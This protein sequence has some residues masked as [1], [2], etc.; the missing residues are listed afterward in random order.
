MRLRTKICITITVL[1]LGLFFAGISAVG[2][3]F[4]IGTPSQDHWILDD[5]VMGA[6]LAPFA[7]CLL[8]G[9]VFFIISGVLLLLDLRSLLKAQRVGRGLT[10]SR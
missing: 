2:Q 5:Q 3:R 8:P 4:L 10:G 1:L 6:G 7:Y 9:I